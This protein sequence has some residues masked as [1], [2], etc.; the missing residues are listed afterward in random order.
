MSRMNFDVIERSSPP[1]NRDWSPV[2]FIAW[3]VLLAAMVF[4]GVL[5][6]LV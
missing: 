6:V 2:R 4:W 5:I 1:P 3:T